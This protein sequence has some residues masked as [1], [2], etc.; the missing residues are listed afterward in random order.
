MQKLK[1]WETICLQCGKIRDHMPDRHKI[2]LECLDK[3]LEDALKKFKQSLNN[4]QKEL[5]K[6]YQE[7]EQARTSYII[8]MG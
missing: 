2:C 8:L 4:E 6:N 3:N 5:F 7:A 1:P